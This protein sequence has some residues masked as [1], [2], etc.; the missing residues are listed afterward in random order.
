MAVRPAGRSKG[1]GFVLFANEADQQA[2]IAAKNDTEIED[3]KI[4]VTI[5]MAEFEDKVKAQAEALARRAA[6]NAGGDAAAPA[7][8]AA[9]AASN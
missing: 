4:A 1:F 3:R 9:P 2:A 8:P 5:A 6:N 7:A